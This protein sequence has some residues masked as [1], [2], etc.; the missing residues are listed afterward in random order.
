MRSCPLG[1]DADVGGGAADVER[2]DVLVAG[3]LAGPDAADQ[4]GDRARHQQVD[5]PLRRR[6]DRRHPTRRLHQLHLVLEAR[7]AQR[8]VEARD[9]ARDLRPDVRVQADGREALELAVE[10]QHLVRDGEVRVGE[11]LE[12]D[13]LDPPLV[14]GVEVRVEQ[15]D[16]DRLDAGVA[17]ASHLLA[18]LVLVE[19]RRARRRRAR[20]R[21]P[22]RS[23]GGGA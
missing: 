6:V 16:R 9:V 11:L 3:H 23:A 14:L 17:Q 12:H 15:A 10:R 21:A 7:V 18:H 2:D 4:A 20:S 8:L 1:G 19:R 5:R 22:G 13:L